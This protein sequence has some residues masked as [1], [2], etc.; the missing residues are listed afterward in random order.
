MLSILQSEGMMKI[1]FLVVNKYPNGDAGSIRQH[2]FALIL[3]AYG[4]NVTILSLNQPNDIKLQKYEGVSYL[5]FKGRYYECKNQIREYLS[6]S[7]DP[8]MIIL[9]TIPLPAFRY[10]KKYAVKNKISLVHD[11]VEWHSLDQYPLTDIYGLI[12]GLYRNSVINRFIL[13]KHFKVISISRYLDSYFKKKGI[14]SLRIPVI[15]N[16]NSIVYHKDNSGKKLHITYAGSPRGKDY[17]ENIILAIELLNINERQKLDITLLGVNDTQLCEI[18]KRSTEEIRNLGCINAL[19]R[20]TRKDVLKKLE[21]TDFT[22]LIRSEKARYAK[23]GF[24]TKVVES[25]ASATPV[26]LNFTS[27]L[28]MYLRDGY[29]CLNVLSEDPEDI[30]VSIRRALELSPTEKTNMRLNARKTAEQNFDSSKYQNT[31]KNFLDI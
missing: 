22:I 21:N 27:D 17:L 6:N 19:G 16:A 4:H 13:D 12:T 9:N 25:L 15:M 3:K 29:D 23:A 1:L 28:D 10:V 24:P 5:A 8:D 7:E 31:L 11:A 18:T 20:V 26:I 14:N 30:V 2:E